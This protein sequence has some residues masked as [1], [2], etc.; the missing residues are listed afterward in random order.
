MADQEPE[1]PNPANNVLLQLV[2]AHAER[3]EQMR[4]DH[5][6]RAQEMMQ[7]RY[8]RRTTDG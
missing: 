7:Q 6:N 2:I 4:T 3:C 8:Q 1:Q 5:L